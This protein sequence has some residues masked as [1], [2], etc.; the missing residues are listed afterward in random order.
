MG[1]VHRP[2]WVDNSSRDPAATKSFYGRLFGWTMVTNEDPAYGGY[3]I[4]Q[5]DG[6]DAAGFGGQQDPNMP[7][8]VWN[9]YIG[10]RDAAADAAAVTAAGGTVIVP[11]FAVGEMGT[12]GF[13]RDPSGAVIGLWQSARMK[14]F[15]AHGANAFS[16][17]ELNARGVDTAIPF[18][19]SVFGWTHRTSDMGNG[20]F[21]TEFL[22]GEDS[23][24]GAQEMPPQLP[25]MVPSFW[26]AYF[27]VED[28]A[29]AH[30]RALAAGGRSMVPA[31]DFPGG[32][33]AIV[34]DPQGGVFGLLRMNR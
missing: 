24:A 14:G 21:Y 18:H 28:V 34:A 4:A 11:P 16:W 32:T 26:L 25:P 19:E 23:L 29:A 17:A 27:H 13:V 2:V 12:M 9:V 15:E 6:K 5:L 20:S 1:T 31:M 33:F 10:T 7:A 22:D 30:G 3:T 8:S